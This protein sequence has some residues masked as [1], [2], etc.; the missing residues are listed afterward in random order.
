MDRQSPLRFV[1]AAFVIA[2][3]AFVIA[4]RSH[5]GTETPTKTTHP[6]AGITNRAPAAEW[7]TARPRRGTDSTSPHW[8]RR[9][10]EASAVAPYAGASGGGDS[11]DL[12]AILASDAEADPLIEADYQDVETLWKSDA[13]EDPQWSMEVDELFRDGFAAHQVRGRILSVSCRSLVCR[14]E[15]EFADK[16]EASRYSAEANTEQRQWVRLDRT[17]DVFGVEV[18]LGREH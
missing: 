7:I 3:I 1:L 10:A 14:A 6:P 16:A 12:Q 4:S 15:L 8:R 2:L 11:R 13:T 17:T 18:F 9:V 5:D